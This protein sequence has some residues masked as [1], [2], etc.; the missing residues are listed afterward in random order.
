MALASFNK[1]R[2]APTPSGF[3]HLGN[4]LSF[5]ITA[6]VAKQS[7]AKILL[8]IDDLD[9][10]RAEK[11]YVED[12]FETLR[13]LDIHWHEGPKY[14]AAYETQW[15]QIHR[16]SLYNAALQQLKESGHLFAC[17]C[18]R[19]QVLKG[20]PDGSYS[21]ACRNKGLPLDAPNACWRVRTDPNSKLRIKAW[22][23]SVIEATLPRSMKDFIVR[24]KDGFPAYQLSSLVDDV[25]FGIDLV[26][27]GQDL[28]DSTL[29]QLYLASLLQQ[30][31]FTNV[32]FL[33]H[34]LLEAAPGQK[35]SKSAGDTSIQYLRKEGMSKDDLYKL[36]SP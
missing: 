34:P 26:V 33:H 35:L 5:I 3:L 25:H 27:R 31:A 8:R 22:E 30:P 9:R 2:I 20:N 32:T 36:I 18:S 16:L 19:T 1:T 24:K 28:W 15:S 21:G 13:F 29:A 12:I 7:N 6:A 17:T 14:F 23:G 4:A 11:D 10:E